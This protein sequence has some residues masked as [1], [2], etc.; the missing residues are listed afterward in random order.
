MKVNG[1]L[2]RILSMLERAREESNKS[3][4]LK[5]IEDNRFIYALS[6]GESCICF[7]C[8]LN[9]SDT[10]RVMK[11]SS[12]DKDHKKEEERKII[13]KSITNYDFIVVNN[14]KNEYPVIL[15]NDDISETKVSYMLIK[16]EDNKRINGVIISP[17]FYDKEQNEL[18]ILGNSLEIE[19]S[20]VFLE[21]K[22]CV[23]RK[24][25]ILKDGRKFIANV[26]TH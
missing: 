26:T 24:L 13:E 6:V 23:G 17:I 25:L 7:D 11:K 4:R 18:I 8:R 19:K 14:S 20:E 12:V 16:K 2:N 21:Q 3:N 5:P 1:N 9:E 15:L 22:I 10:N